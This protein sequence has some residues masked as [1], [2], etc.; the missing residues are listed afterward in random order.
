MLAEQLEMPVDEGDITP[1]IASPP[2]RIPFNE[3]V[4][5][6][7][8]IWREEREALARS[9]DAEAAAATVEAIR[10]VAIDT[11][12]ID[13]AADIDACGLDLQRAVDVAGKSCGW[14]WEPVIPRGTL[15]L[16]TGEAGIGK[17]FLMLDLAAR[18]TCGQHGPLDPLRGAPADVLLVAGDDDLADTIQPRLHAAGA[19]L[20]RVHVV[21][22][23]RRRSL[24]PLVTGGPP[25]DGADVP[26]DG[27]PHPDIPAGSSSRLQLDQDLSFLE[28]ELQRLQASGLDV[29]LLIID[30]VR[31]F[32]GFGG[33][34]PKV[35]IEETVAEL[36][37]LAKRR[38]VAVV[39]ISDDSSAP[40][41]NRRLKPINLALSEAARAVWSV[42]RDLDN[43]DR[44]LLLPV[45][46]R[47]APE[48]QGRAFSIQEGTLQWESDPVLLSAAEFAVLATERKR[49]G[50]RSIMAERERA[51]ALTWLARQLA[52]GSVAIET[53]RKDAR[54]CNVTAPLLRRAFFELG[55]EVVREPDLGVCHWILRASH[56][57]ISRASHDGLHGDGRS[58]VE[59]D[60]EDA[61][62]VA[63]RRLEF[64][65]PDTQ[66]AQ[67]AQDAPPA[68]RP[69][70]E[71]RARTPDRVRRVFVTTAEARSRRT[72]EKGLESASDQ[73]EDDDE[74]VEDE[75]DGTNDFSAENEERPDLTGGPSAEK[76]ALL[77]EQRKARNKHRRRGR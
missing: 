50:R 6:H 44:R 32:T 17:S 20:A 64:D 73:Y 10:P 26:A 77:R 15:T 29:P 11:V 63:A 27:V 36:S 59:S 12:A 51:W 25:A 70:I 61:C 4:I 14:I 71:P 16:L 72:P 75:D 5:K 13:T 47:F 24:R 45:K 30:P 56:D 42:T 8:R 39:V 49:G 54:D 33:R 40:T 62:E 60:F 3:W 1:V 58:R 9:A 38:D 34:R 65:G 48:R 46:T 67:G 74:E 31:C 53:L 57:G 76:R 52:D 22:G 7:Q 18:L 43:P 28:A 2:Q 19:D 21:T 69:L 41:A 68:R 66:D 35:A 23:V 55:C 37:S